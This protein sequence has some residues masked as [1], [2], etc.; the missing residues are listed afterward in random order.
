MLID[1]A[2]AV[3]LVAGVSAC[4]NN[5][6]FGELNTD[7]SGGNTPAPQAFSAQYILASVAPTPFVPASGIAQKSVIGQCVDI[8]SDG[9]MVQ[10]ILY[11]QDT[12][13][14]ISRETDTWTYTLS[15]SNIVTQDPLSTAGSPSTII[16]A[17]TDN[18]IVITRLLRNDGLSVTRTLTFSKLAQGGPACGS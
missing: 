17:T 18:Q 13:A 16:G 1:A 4:G 2:L 9:T 3:T 10:S 11:T 7:G 12:P 6:L 14:Q 8:K 15:G 5:P